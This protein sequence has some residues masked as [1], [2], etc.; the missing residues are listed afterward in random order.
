MPENLP[1]GTSYEKD[2]VDPK[3]GVDSWAR[4]YLR[5]EVAQLTSC[6]N[7]Y[8]YYYYYYHHHH[9]H[10]HHKQHDFRKKRVVGHK[11]CVLIFSTTVV[12]NISHSMNN[13]ARYCQNVY[14][15]SRKIPVICHI[16][17]KLEFSSTDFQK[18]FK[19]KISWT[20]CSVGAELFHGDRH[21]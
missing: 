2:W 6:S 1:H 13:S 5:C 12:R 15:S 3:V 19:C 11:M 8:Y 16:L 4:C 7:Y 14:W 20:F 9:H 18:V 21:S 17:M 10:H